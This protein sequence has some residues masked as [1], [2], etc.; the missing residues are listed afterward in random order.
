M[1]KKRERS[2]LFF[3]GFATFDAVL[4]FSDMDRIESYPL[5][6]KAVF[7]DFFLINTKVIAFALMGTYSKH[8][9]AKIDV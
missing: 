1:R 2:K 3:A 5:S 4:E 6:I 7:D 8:V 9:S